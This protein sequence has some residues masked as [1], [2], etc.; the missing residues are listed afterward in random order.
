MLLRVALNYSP[1]PKSLPRGERLDFDGALNE[2]K[3]KVWNER[4]EEGE[5]EELDFF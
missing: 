1:E 5:G 3:V 4:E 2:R